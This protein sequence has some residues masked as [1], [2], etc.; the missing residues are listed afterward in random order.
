MKVK[1][2]VQAVVLIFSLFLFTANVFGC[3]V[4][5]DLNT[6]KK[7]DINSVSTLKCDGVWAILVNSDLSNSDWSGVYKTLGAGWNVSEDNPGSHSDYDRVKTVARYVNAAM[8]YNETFVPPIVGATKGIGGTILSTLDIQQQSATH[9]G[10]VI[11]LTRSYEKDGWSNAVDAALKN[12]AVSGVV[13]ECYPN[14]SPLYLD[15]LRVKDLITACLAK[16]KNFYFLSPGYTNYTA[17]MKGYIDLLINEGID[18]SDD[19]IFL[20]AASYDYIAPFIGGDESVEGVVKYYL[21]IKAR[22]ATLDNTKAKLTITGNQNDGNS[23]IENS[24]LY[25]F[26]NGSQ[27]WQ[28][29]GTNIDRV[30]STSSG[31][32]I[33]PVSGN[34]LWLETNATNRPTDYRATQVATANLDLSSYELIGAVRTWGGLSADLTGFSLK[35]KVWG[36]TESDTISATHN[37]GNDNWTYFSFDASQWASAMN[38]SRIWIGIAY[39]GIYSSVSNWIG[40]AA[41]DQIGLNSLTTT[42]VGSYLKSNFDLRQNYPNPFANSTTIS[43]KVGKIENVRLVILDL[44]GKIIKNLADRSFD[45]GSF[46]LIWNGT[47]DSGKKVPNGIYFC[48]LSTNYDQQ[49]RTLI[50]K[51]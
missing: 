51:R 7:A 46:D 21:S 25:D 6:L 36:Q 28:I 18:F 11:V 33:P 38:V 49:T 32:A 40:K 27:G 39:N 24:V 42:S 44:Y 45:P 1:C 35:V 14:R 13:L 48:R 47:D 22:F 20:V 3:N 23:L 30:I 15:S 12:P 19:R 16:N 26:E 29:G 5:V 50:L 2:N 41:I 43:V 34:Y 9:G 37:I 31:Q 17:Y 10:S 8:C 4:L